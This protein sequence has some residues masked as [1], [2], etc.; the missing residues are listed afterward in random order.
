MLKLLIFLELCLKMRK[1]RRSI[2]SSNSLG[3]GRRH[4]GDWGGTVPRLFTKVVFVNRLEPMRK[5][6]GVWGV[7]SPTIFEFQ[8]ELSG[9]QR[10]DLTYILSKLFFYY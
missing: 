7:T 8:P 5:K 6:L 3:Q 10:P 4:G 2:G 1:N 9:F